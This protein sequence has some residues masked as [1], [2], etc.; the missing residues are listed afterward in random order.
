MPLPGIDSLKQGIDSAYSQAADLGSKLSLDSV[1]QV[2]SSGVDKVSNTMKGLF[3]A[4]PTVKVTTSFSK[5]DLPKPP[6]SATNSFPEKKQ[7]KFAAGTLF[8][9][10]TQKYYAIFTFNQYERIVV[11]QAPKEKTSVTIVLPMPT[12]LQENFSVEYETPALGAITGSLSDSVLKGIRSAQ[13]DTTTQGS[14]AAKDAGG[15]ITA[16]IGAGTINGLSK[17]PK[18]GEVARLTTGLTPNP[19]LAVLFKNVNLRTHS[20]QY[21]FAPASL[22]ELKQLKQIIKELKKRMLPGMTAGSDML[23]TFPDTVDITFGPTKDV[24]YKIKK[25]VMESL[26]VNYSPNGPAFFKTGDP[27]IVDISMTF[28]EMSPYTRLDEGAGSLDV[29]QPVVDKG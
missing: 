21:R 1:K 4:A 23:F 16:A 20:F 25:C 13:G 3:S 8:F 11:N 17:I 6:A 9:P 12:N 15:S 29:K 24:P 2:I 5:A 19:Y 22:E 14:T 7:P 27:V 18:A 26:S 28:K 10:A